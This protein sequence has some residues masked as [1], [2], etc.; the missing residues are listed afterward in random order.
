M[1]LI[2]GKDVAD[3]LTKEIVYKVSALARENKRLPKLA[4]VRVGEKPGDISYEKS[5]IKC[6]EKCGIEHVE[7]TFSEDVDKGVFL[8]GFK[9]IN[10]DKNIDG[11]LVL[12]PLPKDMDEAVAGKIAPDKDVDCISHYNMGKLLAGEK[13]CFAP[14]TALAVEKTLKYILDKKGESLR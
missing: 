5:A 9:K 4:I 8:S 13:D 12:R 7:C 10:V 6:M 3:I 14:C 11:I 1:E 2:Y